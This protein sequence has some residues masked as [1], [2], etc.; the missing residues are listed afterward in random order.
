MTTLQSLLY[1]LMLF[2]SA[3][4]FSLQFLLT[5]QYQRYR[6]NSAAAT[7]KLTLFAYLTIAVLFFVK[8]AISKGKLYV[9]FT[10]FTF[11]ITIGIA[12]VAYLCV[13]FG[14][15]V[16]EIGDM[17]LYSMFMMLGSL[18][19]PT[20][21]GF[22]LGEEVND[23][24]VIGMVL[25]IIAILL[26]LENVD[27]SRLTLKALLCYVAV[28]VFNGM[29]GVFLTIHQKHPQWT[30]GATL[31]NGAY[32]IDSDMYMFW[33]GVSAVLFSLFMLLLLGI[34]SKIK[35]PEEAV[36]DGPVKAKSRGIMLFVLIIPAIYGLCNGIG[37]YFITL[38]TS[39]GKLGTSVTFPIINGGTILFSTI[40]G[41]LLFKEKMSF[42][43]IL[44]LL[45]IIC[46]MLLFM[47]ATMGE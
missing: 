41:R 5:K 47:F 37:D 43:T 12:V 10:P 21:T 44:S 19:L 30:A 24:K 38:A 1:Y 36:K 33:Y 35:K 11:L 3:L 14:V 39:P 17:G 8:L 25:M 18:I 22:I 13:F 27:K 29:I 23:R 20:V 4:I 32:T 9:D 6:G 42:K 26:S 46:A 7:L 34:K 40:I 15:R 2:S 31:N 28:F 16:L 45:I